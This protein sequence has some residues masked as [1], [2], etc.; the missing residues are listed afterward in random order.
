VVV[1]SKELGW[2]RALLISAFTILLALAAGGVA[3][4]VLAVW[5]L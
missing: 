3:R 1:L 5:P 2:R 4:Q